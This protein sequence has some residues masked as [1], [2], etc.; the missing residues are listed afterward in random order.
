MPLIAWS[1]ALSVGIE[2]IDIE[3]KKLVTI[4][5]NLYDAINA[6]AEKEALGKTL[7]ELIAYTRSHFAHEERLFAQTNY[8]ESAA[9]KQEHEKLTNQVLD[10][11]KKFA[12]GATTS[13]SLEVMDILKN[14]LIYHIQGSDMKFAPHLKSQGIH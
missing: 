8:P 5:N 9:H 7:A 6:N 4:A 11:Q 14:W 1:D 13:L 10:M 3:H 2:E 12:N